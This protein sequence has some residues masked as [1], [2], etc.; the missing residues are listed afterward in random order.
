MLS[1]NDSIIQLVYNRI[2]NNKSFI[3]R[4]LLQIQQEGLFVYLQKKGFIKR[5]LFLPLYILAVPI[6]I[7][8][9]LI[10]PWFLVRWH[11]L[12][13]LRIGHLATNTELYLCEKDAQLNVPKQNYIDIFYLAYKPISNQQLAKMWKRVLHIW[14]YWILEPLSL[15]NRIIPG[16][17][18]HNIG[19][20]AQGDLD[21]HNL[22]DR[23]DTHLRFT[24]EEEKAGKIG[25]REMGIPEGT[26]FVCL[27]V[28]DSAYLK[29]IQTY[30]QLD[31]S[32]HDYRDCNIQSY[33]VAAEELANRGY[34]VI[35]MGV[36]VMEPFKTE[37]PGIIDYAI[38]GMRTDFMDI[39]LGAKCEFCI[40]VGTGFDAIPFVS[41]RPIV[42]TNYVPLGFTSTSSDKFLTI[43]KHH[44]CVSEN[45]R[46]S[47]SELF[48][49]GVGYSYSSS[50]YL[51]K[52][53]KLIENT[54][55]EI[56]DAVIEMA[57]RLNGSWKTNEEDKALQ[58]RFWEIFRQEEV[59]EANGLPFHGE[60]R[61]RYGAKFLRDNLDWLQ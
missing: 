51:S 7:V 38:N 45:R 13:S 15:V 42:Y 17:N 61:A 14:P 10:R 19:N 27:I 24:P 6:I 9:R 40:S 2:M 11:G 12:I 23:F 48:E 4:Q 52:G 44:F 55:E 16:G 31:M 56:R 35:R 37:H 53:I 60:I 47:L 30:N 33:V 28:R 58:S 43:T 34:F 3:K 50:G 20:N 39:Y 29:T 18:M 32:Y 26:P 8:I 25:L 49:E 21:I 36:K 22:L 41:R 5:I 57:E 1:D 46:L 59:N 54:P